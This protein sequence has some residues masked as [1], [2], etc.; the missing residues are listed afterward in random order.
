MKRQPKP[1]D[2]HPSSN[3]RTPH[4]STTILCKLYGENQHI[5]FHDKL[6]II[7]CNSKCHSVHKEENLSCHR[8]ASIF[9]MLDI[10]AVTP[11]SMC[12]SIC[13]FLNTRQ[14]ENLVP[15]S[16]AVCE[17]SDYATGSYKFFVWINSLGKAVFPHQVQMLRGF[18]S[19][20]EGS[21]LHP[22]GLRWNFFLPTLFSHSYLCT[23]L[24]VL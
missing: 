14:P 9:R 13:L 21:G 1:R 23:W 17:L 5:T 2:E 19:C 10:I 8:K 16:N 15:C 3:S 12:V 4:D 11:G 24:V 6:H 7:S 18:R 20:S 22:R